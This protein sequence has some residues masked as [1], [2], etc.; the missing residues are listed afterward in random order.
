MYIEENTLIWDLPYRNVHVHIGT[1]GIMYIGHLSRKNETWTYAGIS[2]LWEKGVT[3]SSS[4]AYSP[5]K[6]ILLH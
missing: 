6:Y 2:P 3:Q 4:P 5:E 1:R